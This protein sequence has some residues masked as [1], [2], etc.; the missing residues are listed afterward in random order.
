M[1]IHSV[2][3]EKVSDIISS[4]KVKNK[5]Y[6]IVTHDPSFLSLELL[7][8]LI[9]FGEN[10]CKNFSSNENN[11]RGGD[12]KIIIE[13]KKMLFSDYCIFV[14]GYTDFRFYSIFV[15]CLTKYVRNKNLIKYDKI[16]NRK[17]DIIPTDGGGSTIHEICDGLGIKYKSVYD[18]DK[19]YKKVTPNESDK[20]TKGTETLTFLRKHK[21]LQVVYE[22][23]TK[24]CGNEI[25]SS[26]DIISLIN[27]GRFNDCR[28]IDV[29]NL[30]YIIIKL[31]DCDDLNI[32]FLLLD[33]LQEN[34]GCKFNKHKETICELLTNFDNKEGIIL[35]DILNTND[36]KSNLKNAFIEFV[37]Y[38]GN[39]Y[40]KDIVDNINSCGEILVMD[41]ELKDLE[42]MSKI[43][44]NFSGIKN[45][46]IKMS[47][48]DIRD[49]INEHLD[50]IS[51]KY[52][53]MFLNFLNK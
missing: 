47:N 9:Y 13:R 20:I 2:C 1:N 26:Q 31:F 39:Y 36:I 28:N 52:L 3:S 33:K 17:Y 42:Q 29:C 30:I 38:R 15:E 37:I 41:Y 16:L 46:I 53:D 5:Q 25:I 22:E 24:K 4:S 23:L 48:N 51:E 50:I 35:R 11:N 7:D 21:K 45:D 19:I 34:S 18:Y 6:I 32:N 10:G 27:D 8:N 44:F 14:E 49:K 40:I 12:K 43:L